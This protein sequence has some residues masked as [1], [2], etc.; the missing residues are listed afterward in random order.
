MKTAQRNNTETCITCKKQKS[1]RKAFFNE[2][3]DAHYFDMIFPCVFGRYNLNI[4]RGAQGDGRLEKW[5]G[6]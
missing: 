5:A 3:K 4:K 1:L 6:N 2:G